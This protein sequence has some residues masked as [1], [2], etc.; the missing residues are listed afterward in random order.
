MHCWWE[1]KL[2]WPL[3]KS[4]WKFLKKL[5]IELPPVPSIPLLGIYPKKNE[6]IIWKD[7]LLFVAVL[8][9]LANIQKPPVGL[10]VNEWVKKTH[11][12]IPLYI[13]HCVYGM[14]YIQWNVIQSLKEGYPVI[15]NNMNETGRHYAQWSK[16]EKNKYWTVSLI[17]GIF[18]K[19]WTHRKRKVEK[20]LPRGWEKR[21]KLVKGYKLSAVRWVRSDWMMMVT[22]VNNTVFYN[23]N[24][25][26]T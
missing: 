21:E 5:K 24:L 11:T 6:I 13:V 4:L 8:V 12:Y 9:T 22:I 18:K 1:C 19:S 3:R 7:I 10:S 17:C 23:W 25:P 16:S 20:Q 14:G 2:V 15:C 26:R